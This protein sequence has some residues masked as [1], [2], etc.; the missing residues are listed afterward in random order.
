MD[1]DKK[2]KLRNLLVF[3]CEGEKDFACL[4]WRGSRRD[5]VWMRER[6]E[7]YQCE[8]GGKYAIDREKKQWDLLVCECGS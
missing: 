6:G 1:R 2:K 3:E 8:R 7:S 5:C 4:C